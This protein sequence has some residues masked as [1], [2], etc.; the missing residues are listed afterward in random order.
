MKVCFVFAMSVE[1]ENLLSPAKILE[2]R[3]LGYANVYRFALDGIEAYACVS[4]LGKV[5]AGAAIAACATQYHDI[6]AFVNL[7]IGGSLNPDVA[8]LM[9]VVLS[10]Q[11]VQHDVDT[12]SFG[13]PYGYLSPAGL[14]FL[15]ASEELLK[16]L[17]EACKE[18][19]FSCTLGTMASGDQ[20]ITDD[21][22]KN[23]EV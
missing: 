2:K 10:K 6:D 5:A 22:A 7:G 8:P 15:P 4:G 14:V 11:C 9:S 16:P 1:A 18:L 20:F 12:S 23:P 21:S 19:G 13:D 17:G 3:T